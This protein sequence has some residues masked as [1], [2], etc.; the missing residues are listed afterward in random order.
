MSNELRLRNEGLAWQAIEGQIVALDLDSS[1]YLAAN[2]TGALLW[3]L[4]AEGTTRE[5]LIASLVQTFE[6]E[7]ETA[8]RDVDGFL[9]QLS[10]RC[11]LEKW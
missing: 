2:R 5:A 9:D 7:R 11:L 3:G 8:A 4:L 10:E 1:V 6:V